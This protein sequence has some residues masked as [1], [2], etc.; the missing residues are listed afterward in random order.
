MPSEQVRRRVR[1]LHLAFCASLLAA[2]CG[3]RFIRLPT[4]GGTP[5]PA[6]A[7]LHAEVSK[8]CAGVRTLTAELALSGR[9][10]DQKLRG[11]AL[12]G[13]EAPGA[14]RLEGLAPFGAPA[15]ILA[16]RAGEATLLLPRADRVLRGAAAG[17]ILGAL[18][19]V[20][21]APADLQAILTGCVVP[22]PKP[23]SGAEY[24]KNWRVIELEGD[25]RVYL[26][27]A[28]NAW[29]VR[30]ADRAGWRIEY[31]S[32]QGSFPRSVR[33]VERKTTAVDVIAE[34]SQLETNVPIDAAAF[35]VDVPANASPIS[36]EE[37]RQAGPLRGTE[38]SD[39]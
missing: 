39:R 25:A 36:L 34:I 13:F 2:G 12:A 23:V 9:A 8:Q 18:T 17:E 30:A 16:A 37:L 28:G 32:W 33:L 38:S 21:L 5:L 6:F 27:R 4:G 14:M 31:A 24:G 26:R 35:G 20:S 11:R 22:A 19:G 7:A 1:I 3:P 29:Q 10:G 15:F